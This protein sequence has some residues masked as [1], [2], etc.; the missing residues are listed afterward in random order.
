ML[1]SISVF[2]KKLHLLS[3]STFLSVPIDNSSSYFWMKYY[4]TYPL[5]TV[6]EYPP[7]LVEMIFLCPVHRALWQQNVIHHNELNSAFPSIAP[8]EPRQLTP[9][10]GQQWCGDTH[11]SERWPC[12][13]P[14]TSTPA[15]TRDWTTDFCDWWS[16]TKFHWKRRKP[17]QR[18]FTA[19]HNPSKCPS[20]TR[21]VCF[22]FFFYYVYSSISFKSQ[23]KHG[24]SRIS[25]PS[26]LGYN[27]IS[28]YIHLALH[29]P[30]VLNLCYTLETLSFFF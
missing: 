11:L 1:F 17:A 13:R 5:N 4:D 20:W 10:E 23:F 24:F 7:D 22:F 27:R 12:M 21:S 14:P 28:L 6:L 16:H 30:A 25:Q 2:L 19:S 8:W 26:L 15:M 29:T 3:W 9:E 18:G